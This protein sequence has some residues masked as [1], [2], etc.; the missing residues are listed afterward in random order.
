MNNSTNYSSQKP[1]LF[2]ENSQTANIPVNR[3]RTS[4]IMQILMFVMMTMLP[5]GC[6]NFDDDG[7]P[8]APS[9]AY[10]GATYTVENIPAEIKLRVG[11]SVFCADADLRVAFVQILQAGTNGNVSVELQVRCSDYTKSIALAPNGRYNLENGQLV[12]ISLKEASQ[13]NGAY[14]I[15][16]QIGTYAYL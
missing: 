15:I 6:M 1:P 8:S 16:V 4:Y 11:E 12:S 2:N 14:Q 5:C 9:V 3:S 7:T 13:T 10:S